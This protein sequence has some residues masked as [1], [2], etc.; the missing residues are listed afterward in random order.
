M[1]SAIITKR[2]ISRKLP[3]FLTEVVQIL[4]SGHLQEVDI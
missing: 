2:K 3:N 1:F 4:S